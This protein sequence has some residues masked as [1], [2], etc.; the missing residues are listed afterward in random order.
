MLMKPM[1]YV[2]T[3]QGSTPKSEWWRPHWAGMGKFSRRDN[4]KQT[5]RGD[6]QMVEKD[7]EAPGRMDVA[8]AK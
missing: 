4:G 5:S 6:G 2:R 7:S 3:N 1:C 8:D